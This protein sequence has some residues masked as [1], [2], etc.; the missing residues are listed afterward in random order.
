MEFD[1]LTV[2]WFQTLFH[3]LIQGRVCFVIITLD[4]AADIIFL[5]FTI[6]CRGELSR[7]VHLVLWLCYLSHILQILSFLPSISHTREI[8]Y[9]SQII[10]L[11]IWFFGFVYWNFEHS[12]DFIYFVFSILCGGDYLLFTICKFNPDPY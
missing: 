4:Y 9:Q 2:R 8:V 6:S 5:A 10:N 11:I 3:Y 1:T 7:A 12:M